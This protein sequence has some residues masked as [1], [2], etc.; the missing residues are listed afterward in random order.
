MK[1]EK[2][3]ARL[4]LKLP[5]VQY[6]NLVIDVEVTVS[7]DGPMPPEGLA[8]LQKEANRLALDQLKDLR[9][10]VDE[11]DQEFFEKP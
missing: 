6:G 8:D 7:D 2:S 4:E 10:Q 5:T 9:Q 11:L 1:V 3:K